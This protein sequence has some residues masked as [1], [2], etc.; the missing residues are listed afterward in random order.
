MDWGKPPHDHSTQ[1]RPQLFGL[2]SYFTVGLGY[3]GAMI[4]TNYSIQFVDYPTTVCLFYFCLIHSCLLFI[5][6][7]YFI[8][9]RLFIS[10][11]F[12]LSKKNYTDFS[13]IM[14]TNSSF[15]D[16]CS[17]EQ[18]ILSLVEI[19]ICFLDYNWNWIVYG[20]ESMFV[21]YSCLFF[22][23]CLFVFVFVLGWRR[24]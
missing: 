9:V 19:F 10:F 2:I 13:K 4:S 1:P 15:V 14:Q 8:L 24:T 20:S 12:S 7:F 11:F 5:C 17:C 23:S 21:Y 16:G 6:L 18:K 22:Y 3:V